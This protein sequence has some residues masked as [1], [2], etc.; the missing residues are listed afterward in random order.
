MESTKSRTINDFALFLSRK[1][2]RG[3]SIALVQ[4]TLPLLCKEE[5]NP[6]RLVQPGD[7]G[8]GW[9]VG[10]G[11]GVTLGAGV[12]DG[13]GVGVTVAVGLGVG[14]GVGVT[15]EISSQVSLKYS[16]LS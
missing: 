6:P 15:F 10:R 2:T 14:V 11:L 16:L 7:V 9:G 4:I 5:P 8:R 12:A 1:D 3:F 13:L